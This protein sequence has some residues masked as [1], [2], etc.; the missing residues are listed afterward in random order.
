MKPVWSRARQ[1]GLAEEDIDALIE[2]AKV[3]NSQ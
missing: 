3:K 1:M 2:E